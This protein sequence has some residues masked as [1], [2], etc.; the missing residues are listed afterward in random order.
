MYG[1]PK[2]KEF[3]EWQG[4]QRF[5]PDNSMFSKGKAVSVWTTDGCFGGDFNT[6]KQIIQTL[7]RARS[8]IE[9]YYQLQQPYFQKNNTWY[10]PL[11]MEVHSIN[12]G[13]TLH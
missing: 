8:T 2:S 5:G 11:T 6:R 12:N 10:T 9:K 4:K 13:G 3:L 7:K 1:K